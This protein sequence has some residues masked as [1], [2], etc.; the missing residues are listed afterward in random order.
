M[1]TPE[2][3]PSIYLR[4]SKHILLSCSVHVLNYHIA[5]N[6]SKNTALAT[7]LAAFVNLFKLALSFTLLKNF[8]PQSPDIIPLDQVKAT[9]VQ[10]VS[11]YNYFIAHAIDLD[12][13]GTLIYI[14]GKQ[15]DGSQ[16][17]ASL[18]AVPNELIL[19]PQ[20]WGTANVIG[21]TGFELD[22]TINHNQGISA[23]SS[24]AS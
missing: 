10:L 1:A 16:A 3:F 7:T 21:K 12:E 17:V 5:L 2:T 13:P 14:R 8:C 4:P 18:R 11:A 24:F 22:P 6:S 19:W 15:D 23:L 20:F 9:P